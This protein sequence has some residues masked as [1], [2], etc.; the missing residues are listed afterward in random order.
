MTEIIRTY[1]LQERALMYDW[2]L[3][4]GEYSLPNYARRMMPLF[5]NEFRA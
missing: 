2:C 5:L 4:G 1:A 3:A